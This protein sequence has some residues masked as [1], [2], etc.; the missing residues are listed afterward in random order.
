LKYQTE[1][2]GLADHWRCVSY[3]LDPLEAAIENRVNDRINQLLASLNK[4]LDFVAK[5]VQQV[6]QS[7]GYVRF[8][9]TCCQISSEL[10]IPSKVTLLFS[11]NLR[12]QSIAMKK[13]SFLRPWYPHE[14][15]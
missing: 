6:S 10:V 9:I 4:K 12:C 8:D 13:I 11:V 3:L 14:I 2:V 15:A 5:K 7:T 1:S